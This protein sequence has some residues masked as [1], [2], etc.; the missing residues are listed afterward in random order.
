MG[1]YVQDVIIYSQ[2]HINQLR[3][4]DSVRGSD[5]ENRNEPDRDPIDFLA[6]VNI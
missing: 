6:A 3:G 2:F 4:L 5:F 1:A